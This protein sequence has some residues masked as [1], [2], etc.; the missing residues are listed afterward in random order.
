[1]E[2]TKICFWR[3]IKQIGCKS[4]R[5]LKVLKTTSSDNDF[6]LNV[7]IEVGKDK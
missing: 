7:K 4:L 2:I 3:L 6:H 1:M 5:R